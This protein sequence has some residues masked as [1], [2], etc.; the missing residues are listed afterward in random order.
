MSCLGIFKKSYRHICNQH[1]GI[2]Q[3]SKLYIKQTNF[4]IEAEIVLLGYFW[5]PILKNYFHIKKESLAHVFSCEF[6]KISKKTFFTE[7]PWTT[8]SKELG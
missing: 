6:C 8:A 3:N 4:K 7:H 1:P 2:F 5:A